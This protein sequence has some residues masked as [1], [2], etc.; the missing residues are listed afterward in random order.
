[1]SHLTLWKIDIFNICYEGSCHGRYCR[2]MSCKPQYV[3]MSVSRMRSFKRRILSFTI[4][5]RFTTPVACS[6]RMRVDEIRRFVAFSGGVSSPPR[7]FSLGWTIVTPAGRIPGSPY[8]DRDNCQGVSESPRDRLG[9]YR[10]LSLHMWHSRSK[11]DRSLRLRG[12]F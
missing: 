8:L 4:F 1:M 9:F 2:R 6:I 5:W 10:V 11:S 3:F 7:G 12:G